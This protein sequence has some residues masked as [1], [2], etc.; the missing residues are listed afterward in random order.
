M[1]LATKRE[2]QPKFLFIVKI[3]FGL[4]TQCDKNFGGR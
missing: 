2:L 3:A 4:N 1:N